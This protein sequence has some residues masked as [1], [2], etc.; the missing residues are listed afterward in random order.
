MP[1]QILIGLIRT[2]VVSPAVDMVPHLEDQAMEAD[3]ADT[4]M[5][6]AELQPLPSRQPT[7]PKRP[8]MPRLAPLHKLPNKL[9]PN[10]LHRPL[11]PPNR[12]RLL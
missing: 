1:K 4:E 8:K 11:K 9:P 2:N 12:P 6:L 7:R 5:E 3:P 10:L